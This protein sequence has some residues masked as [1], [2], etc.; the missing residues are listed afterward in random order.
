MIDA[1][2]PH[3]GSAGLELSYRFN[4]L[5]FICQNRGTA[6]QVTES[7][8]IPSYNL[9]ILQ[10]QI[11]QSFKIDLPINS[12]LT[13]AAAAVRIIELDDEPDILRVVELSL[14]R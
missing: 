8:G 14:R 13:T 7:T 11:T 6:R 5:F 3:L 1:G 2:A 9:N 10:G 12:L 4:D